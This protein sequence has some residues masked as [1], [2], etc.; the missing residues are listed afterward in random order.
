MMIDSEP[1]PESSLQQQRDQVLLEL[2]HLVV[3]RRALPELFREMVQRLQKVAS[4]DFMHLCLHDST[5]DTMRLHLWEGGDTPAVPAVEA[6]VDTAS[7]WVWQN[8]QP[9]HFPDLR[10]E[11]RFSGT[12]DRLRERGYRSYCLLPLTAALDKMGVLGFGSSRTSVYG[13]ADLQ[14]M[15]RVAALMA[16][17]VENGA[18]RQTLKEEKQRLQAL[19]KVN[20]AL[21]THTD[22]GTLLSAVGE[23][24][25]GIA[26]LTY[27]SL[28]LQEGTV[29]RVYSLASPLGQEIIG[30]EATVPLHEAPAGLAMLDEETKFF[31]G[32]DLTAI[33]SP[34]ARRLVQAGVQSVCCI[35][36]K[37]SQGVLGVLNLGSTRAQSV[38]PNDLSVL[39]QIANQLAVFF[40]NARAY[41]ELNELKNKL[42]QE[43][44][45]LEDEIRSELN[46]EE[47]IGDDPEILRVLSQA[48]TVA[49]TDATVLVLGETGTGK[50]LIARAVHRMSER[51]DRSFIK[52]NC[53]AIPTGLLESELFG[54]EKGAFTG[55]VSQKIGRLELADKGTLFLDEV[56]DI[57]LEL[58][59][60]LLR[61]LQDQEFERLGSTRTI[62]VN[63]RLVA[64]TNHDLVKSIAEGQFRSDLFYRLH[65]FPI[66]MPPL[67][68]RRQDI[69][70][71]VRY[72]VQKLARRMGKQIDTIPIETMNK[73]MDWN[74]PGNIRELENLV[75]R[76]VILTKGSILHVPLAELRPQPESAETDGTLEATDREHIIRVLRETRGVLSGPGGAAAR[77]GLQRT[78]LQ[79]KMRK[80]G[81]SR[82]DYED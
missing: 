14:L 43:K 35:P 48:K 75:E 47:I 41:Q 50:E 72:F 77:L 19:L 4:L 20:A 46:F 54:H 5:F 53:A 60:K 45:Y 78:T 21:V 81:I 25:R 13:T 15:E 44:L 69:P 1:Q 42:K 57:P 29:L 11:T 26:N 74:W 7:G 28:A 68:E 73:M 80:L 37:S 33:D 17:A 56:G 59:P 34:F 82:K 3:H 32:S 65:V 8:Q 39:T 30:T 27:G 16:L 24:I 71:L 31:K 79:S 23:G 66:R 12:F 51:R 67:R 61:V 2:V 55:A 18:T 22:L 9:L 63:V 76:S 49:P 38:N 40:Q 36:L 58:Q 52:V 64:A 62:R 10:Q 6:V 70:A